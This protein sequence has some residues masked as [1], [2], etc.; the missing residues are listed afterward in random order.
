MGLVMA[1][2]IVNQHQGFIDIDQAYDQGCRFRIS[3]PL[4]KQELRRLT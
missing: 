1:K 3:F 2:E 4:Q